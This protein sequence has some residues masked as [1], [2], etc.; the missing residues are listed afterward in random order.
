MARVQVFAGQYEDALVST[1]NA[2]L[3]N[4]NNSMVYAVNGW[5]QTFLGNYVEADTA[6][7]RALELDPNNALAHAYYAELLVNLGTFEDIRTAI[8][9][10]N[11]ALSLA[12]NTLETH[13]IRGLVLEVTDNREEAIREYEAAI[14]INGNIPDLHLWLGRTYKVLG[15]LDKAVEEYSLANSLNPSDPTPD[16]YTSRAYAGVG[17]YAKAVQYAESAVRDDPTDPYLRGNLGVMHYRNFE[18][19]DAIDQL[20]FVA[21]GGITEDGLVV[22]PLPL[23]NDTYVIEYYFTYALVLARSFRCPDVLPIAQRIL[24]SVPNDETAVYNAQESLRL[25]EQ[26]LLTPSPTP[27]ITPQAT[28][29]P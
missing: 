11:I 17:E 18:W 29:T 21:S 6:I 24:T 5:A 19:S 26:S 28:A 9:V 27:T 15:V 4:P 13:R 12:P 2:L 10:S 25:C 3:L 1:E 8:D 20:T 14:A 16:L 22:E 23:T 7:Q